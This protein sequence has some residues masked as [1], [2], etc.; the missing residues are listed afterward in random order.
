MS[1]PISYL[2]SK[3][4]ITELAIRNNV[5]QSHPFL[6]NHNKTYDWMCNLDYK[7]VIFSWFIEYP[8]MVIYWYANR[9]SYF[10]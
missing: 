3:Q 1:Y 7:N 4:L 10:Q 5:Q 2:Q 6:E 8:F 9:F